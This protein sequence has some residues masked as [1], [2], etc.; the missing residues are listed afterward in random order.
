MVIGGKERQQGATAGFFIQLFCS[1]QARQGYIQVLCCCHHIGRAHRHDLIQ[2]VLGPL[3]VSFF[4]KFLFS[5]MASKLVLA[6][7]NFGVGKNQF[8]CESLLDI[9]QPDLDLSINGYL[10]YKTTLLVFKNIEYKH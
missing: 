2:V 4:Q 5:W 9:T 7:E 3:M 1:V 10:G 6:R 8:S